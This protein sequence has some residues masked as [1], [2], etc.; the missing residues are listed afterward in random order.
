MQLYAPFCSCALSSGVDTVLRQGPNMLHR[1]KSKS[2][3]YEFIVQV[4]ESLLN[5]QLHSSFHTQ[6]AN[7]RETNFRRKNLTGPIAEKSLHE[8]QIESHRFPSPPPPK[9]M[10]HHPR[11]VYTT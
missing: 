1:Q 10:A 5:S 9:K 7:V 3:L 2:E 11:N 6:I 8:V 4:P